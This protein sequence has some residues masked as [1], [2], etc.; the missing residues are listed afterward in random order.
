M[1]K[2]DSLSFP[3]LDTSTFTHDTYKE[4]LRLSNEHQVDT[5]NKLLQGQHMGVDAYESYLKKLPASSPL[6]EPFITIQSDLRDHANLLS[7]RILELGGTPKKSE[8]LVGKMELFMS[9]L[10]DRPHD[11]KEIVKHAIKGENIYGNKMTE[12]K[13]P[14]KNWMSTTN[15]SSTRFFSNSA[16][17]WMN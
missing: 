4:G 12:K 16:N 9:E 7:T 2:I 8:G 1:E 11:E 10:F 6:K 13:S 15:N 14:V 5:L 17:M 3:S